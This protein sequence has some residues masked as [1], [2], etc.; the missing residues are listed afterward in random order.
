MYIPWSSIL[1]EFIFSDEPPI[2]YLLLENS[3]SPFLLHLIVGTGSPSK[4]KRN[5]IRP[6]GATHV[7]TWSVIMILNV[8]FGRSNLV[9]R[10]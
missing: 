8:L 3:T 9:H 2:L 5:M 1:I 6:V 7:V 4:I 10:N